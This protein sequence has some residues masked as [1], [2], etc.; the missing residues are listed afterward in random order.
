MLANRR[1][2]LQVLAE[3]HAP[4]VQLLGKTKGRDVDK[5]GVLRERGVALEERF[6]VV[7]LADCVCAFELTVVD[8]VDAGDHLL[9]VCDVGCAMSFTAEHQN[10]VP[11]TTGHL[12][13]QGII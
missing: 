2:V 9:V 5:L 13:Q 7:T 4:L 1:G 3:S 12:R 8:T 11:L 6:G 10:A